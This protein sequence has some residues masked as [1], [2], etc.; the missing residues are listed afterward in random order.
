MLM[1]QARQVSESGEQGWVT[2]WGVFR[3]VLLVC[4]LVLGKY[5]HQGGHPRLLPGTDDEEQQRVWPGPHYP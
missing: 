1:Q 2:R 5:S 4:M 3:P